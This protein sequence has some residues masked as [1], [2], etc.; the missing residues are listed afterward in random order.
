MPRLLIVTNIVLFHLLYVWDQTDCF[1][2]FSFLDWSIVP[3]L[4]FR[5]YVFF[6]SPI[7]K[8]LINHIKCDTSVLPR[9]GALREVGICFNLLSSIYEQGI[10]VKLFLTEITFGFILQ[11]N[12][13]YFPIDSQVYNDK[14]ISCFL[15]CIH[16]SGKD[17]L[18]EFI[19]LRE[20][21]L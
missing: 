17:Y 8:E 18:D 10:I 3:M 1:F 6:S 12:L 7:P 16:V 20:D 9:I 21:I 19:D 4:L 5:A 11:M 15:Q 2:F 14:T 13:E